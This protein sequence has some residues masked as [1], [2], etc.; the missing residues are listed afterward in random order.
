[1]TRHQ[2]KKLIIGLMSAF[3]CTSLHMSMFGV[4]LPSIRVDFALPADTTSWLVVVYTFPNIL[5]MPLFGRLGDQLGKRRLLL[6]GTG[7][8]IVGCLL[9]LASPTLGWMIVGRIVQATGAASVN[10]LCISIITERFDFT[11]RGRVFGIWNCC[12]PA[13]HVIGPIASGLLIERYGWRSIYFV[14]VGISIAGIV[15]VFSFVSKDQG[16]QRIADAVKSIDWTGFLLLGYF[17]GS[18]IFY[19]S[20]RPITGKPAFQDWRLLLSTV[21]SFAAFVLWEHRTSTRIVDVTLLKKRNFTPSSIS[22]SV[23]M[24]FLG[25]VN[26]LIPLLMVDVFELRSSA[27]GLIVMVHATSM[28]PTMRFGGYLSDSW[29]NSWAAR[30]GILTQM[31]ALLF[32]ALHLFFS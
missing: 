30:I 27:V 5:F 10:P 22:I 12:G 19:V 7:F 11:R 21:V 1:M 20:S 29:S 17:F 4:A 13:V 16:G 31:A 23:R 9:C 24:F 25:S 14:I 2:E 8:F 3:A 6:A 18:F 15:L 26:L 28:V 32:W